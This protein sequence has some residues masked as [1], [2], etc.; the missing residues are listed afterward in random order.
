MYSISISINFYAI[1]PN[2]GDVLSIAKDTLLKVLKKLISLE[3]DSGATWIMIMRLMQLH[4]SC[5]LLFQFP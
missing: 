1:R 5:L 2:Y 3:P 4:L